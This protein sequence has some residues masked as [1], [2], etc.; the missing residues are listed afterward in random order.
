MRY[1]RHSTYLLRFLE[2]HDI[3]ITLLIFNLCYTMIGYYMIGGRV[4]ETRIQAQ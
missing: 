1:K 3:K 2:S 4:I